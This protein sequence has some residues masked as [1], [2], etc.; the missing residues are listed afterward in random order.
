MG[1]L[2]DGR[3]IEYD[4]TTK[5]VVL[6]FT[7]RS[8]MCHSGD[9]VQGGFVTGWLDSAMSHAAVHACNGERVP[10]SLE[11][12]I[13]FFR[14]AHPGRVRAEGWVVRIGQSIAFLE[15]RLFD[16]AGEVLATGSSTA[17]M[18]TRPNATRAGGAS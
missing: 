17:K 11:I 16:A 14:P 5:R 4:E 1:S 2:G 6:E 7:A 3:F 15:G 12:K 10:A 8:E 9:V 18:V 13:S